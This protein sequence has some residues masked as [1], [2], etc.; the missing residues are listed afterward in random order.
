M[1]S[2]VFSVFSERMAVMLGM[3]ILSAP[4]LA[5]ARRWPCTSFAGKQMVSEVTAES[6]LSY[7]FRVLSGLI[8]TRNPRLFQ[9]VVQKGMVSQKD[10][11]RGI[12]MVMP[13]S[14]TSFPEL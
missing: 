8:T 11:T 7:I 5:S 10:S 4:I 9:K 6:P 12:P 3:N 13:R 14:G 1:D 2:L